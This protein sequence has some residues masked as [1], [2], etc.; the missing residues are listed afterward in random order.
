MSVGFIGQNDIVAGIIPVD[1]TTAANPGDWVSMAK[2]KRLTVVVFTAIGTAGQDPV[3]TI[4]EA[5][6]N[7]EGGTQVLACLTD[8]WEKI[9]ATAIGAITNWTRTTQAAGS[10]YTNAAGAAEGEYLLVFDIFADQLSDGYDYIAVDV[11]DVG[12]NAQLGCMLYI[13][14]E[15]RYGQDTGQDNVS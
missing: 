3:I 13:L 10:T 14:S 5:T 4:N 2:H 9:G 1:L 11:A 12:A 7:A 6:N 8:V 15:P